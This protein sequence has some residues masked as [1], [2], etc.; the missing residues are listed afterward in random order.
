[1][2]ASKREDVCD[3]RRPCRIIRIECDEPK[4]HAKSFDNSL[5]ILRFILYQKFKDLISEFDHMYVLARQTQ[6]TFI[7]FLI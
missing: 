6:I 3:A 2:A 1:M 5:M 7:K 4:T